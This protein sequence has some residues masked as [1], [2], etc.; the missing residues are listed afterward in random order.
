MYK[1]IKY[2]IRGRSFKTFRLFTTPA[3]YLVLLIFFMA[4]FIGNEGYILIVLLLCLA[5][6]VP[7]MIYGE[8][9]SFFEKNGEIFYK[10]SPYILIFWAAGFLV[11]IV[12]EVIYPGNLTILFIVDALLAVT[13]GLIIGEAIKTYM[14]YREYMEENS[15]LM[16]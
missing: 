13:L 7:G 3:I 6:L 8:H 15:L 11:R 2:G 12:L 4:A 9:V 5:G 1:R 16:V 14:K 10:R